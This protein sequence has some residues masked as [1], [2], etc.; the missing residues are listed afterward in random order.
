[1]EPVRLIPYA[2]EALRVLGESPGRAGPPEPAQI[3]RRH[4]GLLV[5]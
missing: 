1:M 3:Y 2:G 5:P 4:N